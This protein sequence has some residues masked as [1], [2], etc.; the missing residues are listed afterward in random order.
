MNTYVMFT[1]LSPEA[2]HTPKSLEPLERSV[3]DHV[4]A[5]CREVKWEASYALLGPYDYLDVFSAP[6]V[7][8]ATKVSALVRTYGHAQTEV[9]PATTWSEFKSVIESLPEAA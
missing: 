8:T 4:R 6:D 9:C 2:A 7:A 3:M 1:R 5:D